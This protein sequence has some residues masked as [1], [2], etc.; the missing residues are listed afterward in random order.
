MKKNYRFQEHKDFFELQEGI[1]K[2]VKERLEQRFEDVIV[3][4][5]VVAGYRGDLD[6]Y[7]MGDC[8]ILLERSS[9]PTATII[10]NRE[11]IKSVV[12]EVLP[13]LTGVHLVEILKERK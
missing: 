9:E 11:N 6:L 3:F 13:K 8:A 5:N 1:S 4:K 2:F 7:N 10:G 12:E